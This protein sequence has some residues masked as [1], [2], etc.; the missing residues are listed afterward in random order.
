[1]GTNVLWDNKF[2]MMED[3][4]TQRM[5]EQEKAKVLGVGKEEP[6]ITNSRG[7]KQSSSPYEPCL[8][9][10][11]FLDAMVNEEGPLHYVAQYMRSPED[12][13]PLFLAIEYRQPG[14]EELN[15]M[16]IV[17]N[18]LLTIS[19]VLKEGAEKYE[20]NNWRLIP[21]EQHLSHAITHYL[22]YLLDDNQDD[23]LSHFYT[24]LM[25]C[26]ATVQT[27]FFSYTDYLTKN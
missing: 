9:D 23:H 17:A 25:M 19:K 26:Y 5:Q 27:P 13:T 6:T 18:R 16:D 3:N 1:M 24:R 11:D 7:G 2:G 22:A 14:E 10:P 15:R 21:S 20:T 4:Y 8:L 12:S